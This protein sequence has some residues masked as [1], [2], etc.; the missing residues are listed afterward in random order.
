MQ[1]AKQLLES[2]HIIP[3][4]VES[5]WVPENLNNGTEG[6]WAAG[7]PVL[8][9]SPGNRQVAGIGGGRAAF[10]VYPDDRLAIIVLTNLVGASP[11]G[12][13]PEIA[14]F[15]KPLPATRVPLVL[16]P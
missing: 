8:D 12:F 3:A 2:F 13:I 1:H 9:S 7:W 11:E 6:K 15:Y 10:V 4:G 5:T 16:A 14:G